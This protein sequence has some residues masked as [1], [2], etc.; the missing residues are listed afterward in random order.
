MLDSSRAAPRRELAEFVR[1]H[2]ERLDPASIG[3]AVGARRRTPGLRR[4]E[5]AQLAGLST[6][7]YAW[8]EQGRE[9]SVS[10]AALGRIAGVLR[11]GRAERA[12]LFALA[13]KSDPAPG[14]DDGDAAPGAVLDAV[15]LIACPAYMLDRGWNAVRWNVPAERLFVGWLDR[16]REHNLLRYIFLEPLARRLI[17]GWEARARRVAAE[18]RAANGAHLHDP[19]LTRLV[20]ELYRKSAEFARC[21]DEHGVLGRDGGL[22]RFNHPT[23]GALSFEQIT[24]DVAG[25]GD[26]RLTMLVGRDAANA[27]P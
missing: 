23:D 3:L 14:S 18:F 5:V 13:G 17:C 10:A 27:A 24:F 19:A 7:W 26:L 22:R 20:E 8:I 6:T 21:W 25:R 1:A 16:D 9:V 2:R 15:R 11:L 12:Y 4:E